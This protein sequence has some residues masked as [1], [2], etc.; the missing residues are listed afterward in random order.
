MFCVNCTPGNLKTEYKSG[1]GSISSKTIKEQFIER[2]LF[3]ADNL[4]EI[5]YRMDKTEM[6]AEKLKTWLKE[7]KGS[8]NKII[9]GDNAEKASN[10]KK[11][12]KMKDFEDVITSNYIEDFVDT[13]YNMIFK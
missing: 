2:D 3:N 1:P 8:I 10:F 11:F 9:K 7:N 6:T 13:N 5:Q 12:F 4:N